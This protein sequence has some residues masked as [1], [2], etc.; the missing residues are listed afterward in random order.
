MKSMVFFSA[1][2]VVLPVVGGL[3]GMAASVPMLIGYFLIRKIFGFAVITAG[4]PTLC[5]TANWAYQK[6]NVLRVLLQLALPACCMGLFALHPVGGQAFAY[7]LYWVIPMAI[8]F[9]NRRVQSVFLVAISST[10]IAHAV[11]SVMWLY[12]MPMTAEQWLGLIPVVAVERLMFATGATLFYF[13]AHP[14][15]RLLRNHSGHAGL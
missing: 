4:L 8:F 1:V 9:I 2:S 13:V 11:G 3:F 15:I 6:N 7:A 12:T 5:A 14:S 10:F